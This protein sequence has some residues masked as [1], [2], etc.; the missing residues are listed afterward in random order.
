MA[1]SDGKGHAKRD[2]VE[3]MI[4]PLWPWKI[5]MLPARG[6]RPTLKGES[7][8]TL[9][10]MDDVQLPQVAASHRPGLAFLWASS[11]ERRAVS[12]R[13]LLRLAQ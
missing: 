6:P 8:L 10:L 11:A 12:E 7:V 1:T 4:P 13:R 5:I 2:M 9:R 3:W